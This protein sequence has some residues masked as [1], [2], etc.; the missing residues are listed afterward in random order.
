MPSPLADGMETI[1]DRSGS[2]EIVQESLKLADDDRFTR[3]GSQGLVGQQQHTIGMET[4]GKA[5]QTQGGDFPVGVAAGAA[6]Q[7]HLLGQTVYEGLAQFQK[8]RRIISGSGRYRRVQG[9]CYIYHPAG[10]ER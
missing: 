9:P 7:I 2:G 3:R 1:R 5:A 4:G 10:I 8:Q 6:Q